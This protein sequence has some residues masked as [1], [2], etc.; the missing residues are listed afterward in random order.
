MLF[1][2][3]A[4]SVKKYVP[5]KSSHSF[6]AGI[7][8]KNEETDRIKQFCNWI[9]D[10]QK[11]HFL[12]DLSDYSRNTSKIAQINVWH[13][14]WKTIKATEPEKANANRA[15]HNFCSTPLRKLSQHHCQPYG[16]SSGKQL[17]PSTSFVLTTQEKLEWGH[18]IYVN[19]D[20]RQATP[21]QTNSSTGNIT[22]S[23]SLSISVIDQHSICVSITASL[24]ICELIV[25]SS[26]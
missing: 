21:R 19:I 8:W 26:W 12:S 4:K 15:C 2:I 7:I 20:D 16:S 5:L 10:G 24:E 6:T 11:V 14:A 1:K 23:N 18:E 22:T 17:I 3:V 13:S 25:S 9:S